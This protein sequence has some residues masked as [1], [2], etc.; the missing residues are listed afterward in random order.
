MV[1]QFQT[2]LLQLSV[3]F[4]QSCDSVPVGF[5]RQKETLNLFFKSLEV[6]NIFELNIKVKLRTELFRTRSRRFTIKSY[7]FADRRI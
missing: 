5:Q 3:V 4:L 7:L 6:L 1:L 2:V